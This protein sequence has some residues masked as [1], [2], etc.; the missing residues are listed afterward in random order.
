[1]QQK[2]ERQAKQVGQTANR[3]KFAQNPEQKQFLFRTGKKKLVECTADWLWG[4]G[5]A[6]NDPN[7]INLTR[8]SGDGIMSEILLTVQEEINT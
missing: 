4:I 5:V 8:W 2:W 1:M 3:C 7:A 6:L